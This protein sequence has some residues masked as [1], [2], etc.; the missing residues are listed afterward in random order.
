MLTWGYVS[1]APHLAWC[2]EEVRGTKVLTP[3]NMLFGI[4]ILSWFLKKQ[5]A[6]KEPMTLLLTCLKEFR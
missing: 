2:V 4:L 1:G 6:L 5:Q 3:Q